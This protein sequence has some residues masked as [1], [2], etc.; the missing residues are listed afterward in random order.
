MLLAATLC[1]AISPGRADDVTGVWDVAAKFSITGGPGDG[2]STDMKAVLELTQKGKSLT[3]TFT[4]YA[5]DRKTA[6]PSV[7]IVDGRVN[8]T[9]VSFRVKKDAQTSL[10]FALVFADGHL[11]GEATPTKEIRG[12]GKLTIKVDATRRAP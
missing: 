6:Q 8:G 10:D 7:P 12:G 1:A 3:G 2:Q 9:K 4:L 11:R 5:E